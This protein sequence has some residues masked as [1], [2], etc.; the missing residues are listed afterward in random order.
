MSRELN[1]RQVLAK[2]SLGEAD[3]A[4]VYK[5]DLL[6]AGDKVRAVPIAAELNVVADYPIAVVNGAPQPE[7][8]QAFVAL[9]VADKGQS[10]LERAGFKRGGSAAA[11]Q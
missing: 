9:V 4:I 6:A 5:T 2:V 7:L 11:A 8:A 10:A 1:A 3:A